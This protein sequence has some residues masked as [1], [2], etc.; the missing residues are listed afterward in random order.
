MMVP[1]VFGVLPLTV[2]FAVFP[3]LAAITLML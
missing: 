3:G 2:L 1:V